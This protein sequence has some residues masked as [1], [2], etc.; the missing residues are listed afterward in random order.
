MFSLFLPLIPHRYGHQLRSSAF[1]GSRWQ[2]VGPSVLQATP[3]GSAPS[4]SLLAPPRPPLPVPT[5]TACHLQPPPL[6]LAPAV[7]PGQPLSARPEPARPSSQNESLTACPLEPLPCTPKRP[8]FSPKPGPGLPRLGWRQLGRA[9][10]AEVTTLWAHV[11]DRSRLRSMGMG[12]DGAPN[13]S[14]ASM[15]PP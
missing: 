11:P 14:H 7:R 2:P 1:S 3:P 5:L 9:A 13:T 4:C 8:P 10:Q 12:R 15:A 6:H